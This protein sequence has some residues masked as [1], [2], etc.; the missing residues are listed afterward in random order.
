MQP[1][2][3]GAPATLNDAFGYITNLKTPTVE[4]MMVMVLVEAASKNLYEA[5]ADGVPDEQAKALLRANGREELGHAHRVARAIGKI[6]GTDYPV[7]SA[8]ENPYLA[9]PLPKYEVNKAMLAGL[10]EVEFNGD[11]LY[12][13]WAD[14]C[15]NADA[16]ALFRE[17]GREEIGH[18]KRLEQASALLAA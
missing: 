3:P 2:P 18:G 14:H 16:A 4:D 9:A 13:A 15:G 5:L 7:P 11:N 12:G 8:A 6:T 17:N 1:L 10:A